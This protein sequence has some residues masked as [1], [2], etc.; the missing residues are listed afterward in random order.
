MEGEAVVSALKR[1]SDYVLVRLGVVNVLIYIHAEAV[2]VPSALRERLHRLFNLGPTLICL[3][4]FFSTLPRSID[5][6]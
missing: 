3:L 1:G 6:F 2:K 5:L 4:G